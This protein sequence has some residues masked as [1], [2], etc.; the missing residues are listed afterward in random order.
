MNEAVPCVFLFLL[1]SRS[2]GFLGVLAVCHCH[3]YFSLRV[4][5]SANKCVFLINA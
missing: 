2:C 3:W 1:V 4:F 5:L